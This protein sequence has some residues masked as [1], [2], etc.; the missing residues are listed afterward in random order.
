MLYCF[1]FSCSI[2]IDDNWDGFECNHMCMLMTFMG[3][4]NGLLGHVLCTFSESNCGK[5]EHIQVDASWVLIMMFSTNSK[6]KLH[7]VKG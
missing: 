3:G 1:K 2:P 6:G 4:H 7:V 5:F